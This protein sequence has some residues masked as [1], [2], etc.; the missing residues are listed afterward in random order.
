MHS[1]W[2]KEFIH[3]RKSFTCTQISAWKEEKLNEKLKEIFHS[4]NC[5]I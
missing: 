5:Q 3:E 4:I 2:E 1:R